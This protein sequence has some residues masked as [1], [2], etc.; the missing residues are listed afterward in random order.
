MSCDVLAISRLFSIIY[1][2]TYIRRQDFIHSESA[3]QRKIAECSKK[4][5]FC[6]DRAT[7]IKQ[8]FFV[9]IIKI[10]F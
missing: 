1:N 10:F 9:I 4:V 5:L 2:Y 3:V 7:G 6:G 8:N